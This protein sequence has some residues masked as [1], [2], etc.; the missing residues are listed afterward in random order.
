[1]RTLMAYTEVAGTVFVSQPLTFVDDLLAEGEGDCISILC[2]EEIHDTVFVMYQTVSLTILT[3]YNL[4]SQLK[5][6]PVVLGTSG[7]TC[8]GI[9]YDVSSGIGLV[10]LSALVIKFSVNN[11]EGG[12]L[13]NTSAA[14]QLSTYGQRSLDSSA[15]LTPPFV[16][17]DDLGVVYAGYQSE[18]GVRILR[19]LLLET[20]S[21]TPT[22]ATRAGDTLLTL[23]GRGLQRVWG[24]RNATS[25]SP[26]SPVGLTMEMK[27]Q[28]GDVTVPALFLH[29]ST[30]A[31]SS[32]ANPSNITVVCVT[33]EIESSLVCVPQYV[34]LSIDGIFFTENQ[35]TLQRPREPQLV[36]ASPSFSLVRTAS[37]ITISGR[38]IT[39]SPFVTCLFYDINLFPNGTSRKAVSSDST[40]TTSSITSTN[41]TSLMSSLATAFYLISAPAVAV[42]LVQS[43][44]LCQAPNISFPTTTGGL[45]VMSLDAQMYSSNTLPFLVYGDAVG[46]VFETSSTSMAYSVVS[47]PNASLAPLLT[48]YITD[49]QNNRLL[50]LDALSNR[51]AQIVGIPSSITL[52][53]SSQRNGTTTNN[54]SF[55]SAQCTLGVC[56]FS[57]LMVRSPTVGT[58]SFNVT[59]GSWTVGAN[60]TS[61]LNTTASSGRSGQRQTAMTLDASTTTSSDST[62][63][64]QVIMVYSTWAVKSFDIVVVAGDIVAISVVSPPYLV[65]TFTSTSDLGIT[66]T[67]TM[68]VVYPYAPAP[69]PTVVAAQ[70]SAGN[71]IVAVSGDSVNAEL[72]QL[73]SGQSITT[74]SPVL[75]MSAVQSLGDASFSSNGYA[76]VASSLTPALGYLYLIRFTLD[77][78]ATTGSSSGGGTQQQT[79]GSSIY[80]DTEVFAVQCTTTDEF[81][82]KDELTCRPCDTATAFCNGTEYYSAKPGYWR[83]PTSIVIYPC[84][85]ASACASGGSRCSVGTTGIGCSV[86]SD[87]WAQLYNG[88]CAQCPSKVL[89]IV[90]IVC[91]IVILL[92]SVAL[93]TILVTQYSNRT[94]NRIGNAV[95]CLIILLSYLQLLVMLDSLAYLNL[96]D[97]VNEV[98]GAVGMVVSFRVYRMQ[99]VQCLLRSFGLKQVHMFLV[100]VVFL[101]VVTPFIA[102]IAHV[103]LRKWPG[104][105]MLSKHVLQRRKKYWKVMA[106]DAFLAGKLNDKTGREAFKRQRRIMKMDENGDNGTTNNNNQDRREG[107]ASRGRDNAMNSEFSDSASGV[108]ATSSNILPSS[109]QRPPP[110]K[111]LSPVSAPLTPLDQSR[112]SAATSRY[113]RRTSQ[114]LASEMDGATSGGG[115]SDSERRRRVGGGDDPLNGSVSI[116]MS[117]PPEGRAGGT[118][119]KK[120]SQP[121]ADAEPDDDPDAALLLY[122][123]GHQRKALLLTSFQTL[124]FLLFVTVAGLTLQAFD[125]VGYDVGLD[126]GVTQVM[127]SD[128]EVECAGDS[129]QRLRI[130]AGLAQGVYIIFVPLV[131]LFYALLGAR[132]YGE[133]SFRAYTAFLTFG[134]R[135]KS[136]FWSSFCFLRIAILIAALTFLEDRS[137]ANIY[138]WLATLFLVAQRKLRPWTVHVHGQ[139]EFAAQS[140]VII[141]SNLAVLF[142]HLDEDTQATAR[143]TLGYFVIVVGMIIPT[144][145]I[146]NMV[147]F[148]VHIA[149][150]RRRRDA[151]QDPE[152][153]LHPVPV[154]AKRAREIKDRMDDILVTSS[155]EEENINER[156]RLESLKKRKNA[157]KDRLRK[158]QDVQ[159]ERTR[160]KWKGIASRMSAPA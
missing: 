73:V 144:V 25:F 129:Y 56:V 142:A 86:C 9:T 36:A 124:L 74:T 38:S 122:F 32:R 57:H 45:L 134:L 104:A 65:L 1:R 31:S 109:S 152:D 128:T 105:L 4:S 16:I 3:G 41:T 95:V 68:N 7:Q 11:I 29:R 116:S 148:A 151:M 93:I 147:S 15:Q 80:K 66:T 62:S 89:S 130:L 69:N 133:D 87:G 63:S 92:V 23:T 121:P 8:G 118:R 113:A 117:K 49:G 37:V 94:K 146:W 120:S 123:K 19:F 96:P 24:R 13:T 157:K 78:V 40:I 150:R 5:Y 39:D 61:S 48:L 160:L 71:L 6:L 54:A 101:I 60:V 103:I 72:I 85:I 34:E 110:G 127:R 12:V 55:L 107:L 81:Q 51:T 137:A 149:Y 125:C 106:F 131:A 43:T 88:E 145:L 35:N 114:S 28:I 17:D 46:F 112:R 70:D 111:K 132:I 64:S 119:S 91:A 99:A 30:S 2:V 82:V 143:T 158:L 59:V 44:F 135:D 115:A 79:S 154:S 102:L 52:E 18:T 33:T 14:P 21:L 20:N 76:T 77:G 97:N 98:L 155:E 141:L 84:T 83:A 156:R 27:C 153:P 42:D 67:V 90:L 100:Y 53:S 22:I 139:L 26:S 126:V 58:Y 136:V 108:A 10:G 75:N 47:S 159:D 138:M 50:A 140:F